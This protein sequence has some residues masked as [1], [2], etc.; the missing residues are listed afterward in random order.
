MPFTELLQISLGN[1]VE[2]SRIPSVDVWKE[3]FFL[4]KK[5]ALLGITYAAIE[6]LP[7]EQRPPRQLILQWIVEAEYIKQRNEEL[8]IKA[9]SISQAFLNDGFRNLI[10][11]GQSAA[12]YYKIN[13]LDLYRTPG[14][15]D[16][17]L[18][19]NRRDIIKYVRS[20]MPECNIL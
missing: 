17:W 9:V 20:K 11:K 19:A 3:L 2:F 14:D 5:Q 12:Q 8:N 13:N 18:D 6:H 10:L 1:R 4:S 7:K 16:I 15:V